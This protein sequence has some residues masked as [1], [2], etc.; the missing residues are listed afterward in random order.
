MLQRI[1]GRSQK[2][3]RKDQPSQL[4]KSFITK[5]IQNPIKYGRETYRSTAETMSNFVMPPKQINRKKFNTK[6]DLPKHNPHPSKS[7]S[8]KNP[9]NR[10]FREDFTESI[11][12]KTTCH[13]CSCSKETD[14]GNHLNHL[15]TG[16]CR[17]TGNNLFIGDNSEQRNAT[18]REKHYNDVSVNTE[19]LLLRHNTNL[20]SVVSSKEEKSSKTNDYAKKLCQ[21]QELPLVVIRPNFTKQVGPIIDIKNSMP[22]SPKN[23]VAVVECIH[24][25]TTVG[26]KEN[27]S[28]NIIHESGIDSASQ[29]VSP[30]AVHFKNSR[31]LKLLKVTKDLLGK[32]NFKDGA[33][34]ERLKRSLTSL[35][36]LLNQ[37]SPIHVANLRI[38]NLDA[39]SASESI[40]T[41]F[42]NID[43]V[44][45][46]IE[47][48]IKKP[49]GR[50]C[51]YPECLIKAVDLLCG[52]IRSVFVIEDIRKRTSKPSMNIG[53]GT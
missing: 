11:Y 41:F 18:Y 52:N 4:R 10:H 26:A 38:S 13:Y 49:T 8:I 40:D 30:P 17:H 3:I 53:S 25:G 27:T 36:T 42:S 5:S 39:G 45:E 14:V 48:E 19:P 23:N 22:S 44:T 32:L 15:K 12:P 51:D 43:L 37:I 47:N 21:I 34:V 31:D 2:E 33:N 29:T 35:V 16:H 46:I 50:Y 9:E 20:I 6:L 1:E 24:G 28:I 7:S